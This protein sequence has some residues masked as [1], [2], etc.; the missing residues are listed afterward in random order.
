M[1]AVFSPTGALLS[2][3]EKF[4]FDLKQN[5]TYLAYLPLAH[6]MELSVEV[7]LMYFGATLCYGSPHTLTPTGIKM[8][9]TKPPQQ[10]DAM[11]ARPTLMVFAPAVLDKVYAK[12]NSNFAAASGLIQSIVKGGLAKGAA[13]YDRGGVGTTD[14]IAKLIFKKVQKLLGGRVQF[15]LTG[16]APLAPDVQ[17]WVQTVFN[18][19]CRQGY[20]LTETCAATCVSV[21]KD[22]T[23]SVV[24]PPQECACLRLRDWPEG[25]YF[26]DDVKNSAIGMRRGEILIGGPGVSKGYY[27]DPA[28]PDPELVEKNQ[29]DYIVIGGI[30]YF[31]TGD[32]GQFTPSGNVQIIDRK[33]DLVKLQQGEYVALSKVENVLKTSK[34]VELPMAYAASTESTCIALICPMAPAL[35]ALATSLGIPKETS[36]EDLCTK[37][38]AVNEAVLADVQKCCKGK[39]VGF[40]TPA[41]VI[42]I[43]DLWTVENDMLT[44]A[45]KLKRKPIVDRHKADIE[46]IGYGL[47]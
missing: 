29:T 40:E 43:A 19:P 22:N 44:A 35:R 38:K 47:K 15:A 7:T 37:H 9:Q 21:A 13:H 27:V 16:S 36:H 2:W 30:R 41:K 8:K 33:K 12:V 4:K 26:N 42:L 17:R 34:Y 3:P 11:A 39:L 1:A 20:G 46:A 6:I 24:G 45:L 10:G 25:G 5:P 32:I 23:V 28:N 18:A 14:C 31:C